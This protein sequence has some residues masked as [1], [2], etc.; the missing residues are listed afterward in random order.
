M[1]RARWALLSSGVAVAGFGAWALAEAGA[2]GASVALRVGIGAA[3]GCVLAFVL[4]SLWPAG[5][6]VPAFDQ[7][8]RAKPPPPAPVPASLRRVERDVVLATGS[9]G[10]SDLYHTLCPMLRELAAHR[11][12]SA[13]GVELDVHQRQARALLGYEL[14]DLVRQDRTAPEDRNAPG[15][16]VKDLARAVERLESL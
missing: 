3:V 9:V 7:A 13:H 14:W 15:L 16:P 10:S 12:R 11:L 2:L 6:A 4:P 1:R 8:V 5:L